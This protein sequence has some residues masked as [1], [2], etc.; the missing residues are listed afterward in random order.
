MIFH[1]TANGTEASRAQY[2]P[3]SKLGKKKN[4]VNTL[5]KQGK[6]QNQNKVKPNKNLVKSSATRYKFAVTQ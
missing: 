3:Q 5:G 1:Q 4:P 6:N 2:E